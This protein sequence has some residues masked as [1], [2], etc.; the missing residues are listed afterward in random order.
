MKNLMRFALLSLVL[1]TLP[2]A[3]QMEW[4]IAGSTGIIDPATAPGSVQFVNMTAQH[5]AG[6]VGQII[7]RYPVTNTSLAGGTVPGW[8]AMEVAHVDNGP[9]AFVT[10][11]LIEVDRCTN[12]QRQIAILN[13]LDG[14]AGPVCPVVG[15][16]PMDFG[17]KV[18]YVE[19]TLN[20][21][22][23]AA[24]ASLQYVALF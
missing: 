16:P 6:A 8:T 23:V 24:I 11:R 22:A 1:V 12:V 21:T 10:V 2:A 7:L 20:R 17:Q 14:P 15:V 4:N 3:A 5:A 9:N 19:V 18:Y 13:S